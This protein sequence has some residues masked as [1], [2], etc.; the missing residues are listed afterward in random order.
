MAAT[1]PTLT[2]N[3]TKLKDTKNTVRYQNDDNERDSVYLE[4]TEAAKLGNPE[5]IQAV[6]SAR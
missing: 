3:Y 4:K 2:V 6:F 5:K 1:K